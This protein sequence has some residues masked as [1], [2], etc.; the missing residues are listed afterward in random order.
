MT[1]PEPHPLAPTVLAALPEHILHSI[2]AHLLAQNHLRALSCVAC[3]SKPLHRATR[4]CWALCS[5]LSP[6][7]HAC[8]AAL[9]AALPHAHSLATLDVSAGHRWMDDA[10]AAVVARVASLQA[11]SFE[12]CALLTAAGLSALCAGRLHNLQEL[13]LR[14]VGDIGDGGALVALP[15][16][17]RLDLGWCHSV[18]GGAVAAYGPR[19]RALSLHGCDLVGDAVCAALPNVEELNVAFTHV[20]DEGLLALARCSPRLQ[21]LTVASAVEAGNLWCTGRWTEAGLA[22]FRRLRPDVRLVFASC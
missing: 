15:A 10:A 17:Q 2:V 12:H 20:G 5:R 4:S 9:G 11:V 19:L 18:Q 21:R 1:Q 16:L 14:S 3:V 7:V 8:T 6:G 22:E 13:S